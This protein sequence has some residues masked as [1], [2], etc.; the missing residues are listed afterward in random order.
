MQNMKYP[1]ENWSYGVC[2]CPFWFYNPVLDRMEQRCL[3][4]CETFYQFETPELVSGHCSVTVRYTS[5][6]N[7][8]VWF[9]YLGNAKFDGSSIE[10]QKESRFA[11]EDR[12]KQSIIDLCDEVFY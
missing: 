6:G 1:P 3:S 5:C 2:D 11:M 4:R 7:I 8:D 12:I 9:T 10:E